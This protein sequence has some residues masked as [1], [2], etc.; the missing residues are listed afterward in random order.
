MG[1][2]LHQAL[3]EIA[4][5]RGQ[6]ARAAEFQGYGPAALAATALVAAAAGVVQPLWIPDPTRAPLHY[7]LLWGAAALLA[8]ALIACE[9]VARTRRLHAGVSNV[10]IRCAVEQFL[11]S[12]VAAAAL[13]FV[14]LRSLPQNVAL[15]PGLWQVVF[16]LGVFAS[17]RFLPRPTLLVGGWYLLTG[18]W[19]LLLSQGGMALQPWLMAAPFV[20]G[21]ALASAILW[22]AARPQRV[23]AEQEA[24]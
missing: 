21:Q 18:I 2:P 14:L 8:G 13:T 22:R 15:L 1:D 12:A 5:I 24:S 17:C 3:D 6:M 4:A 9:A 11:P 23:A 19:V 10:M 7:V 20:V 16:S